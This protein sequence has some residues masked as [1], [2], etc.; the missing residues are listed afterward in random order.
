MA[1]TGGIPVFPLTLTSPVERMFPRLTP[2]Q[3]KR[4]AA[5]GRVRPAQ[6]GEVLIE[7]GERFRRFFVIT[8]GRIEV[9]RPMG[10]AE[11]VVVVCEAGMFTGEVNLL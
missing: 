10:S 3:I 1:R 5:Y 6:K 4:I 9:V 7:A 2:E 11:E 8:A